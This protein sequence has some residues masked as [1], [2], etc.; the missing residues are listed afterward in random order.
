MILV[1][2]GLLARH[3]Q[4]VKPGDEYP[5]MAPNG[6][7]TWYG[8]PK[9][10]YHDG[11]HE[12]TYVGWITSGGGDVMVG[13]YNHADGTIES[14][15]LHEKLENDDHDHPSIVIR[16]DGHVLAFYSRHNGDTLFYRIS[17]RPE[18]ITE[19]REEMTIPL[20]TNC[21]YPNVLQL[22]GEGNRMYV[23]YRGKPMFNTSDDGGETWT[24]PNRWASGVAAGYIKY[25]T[26]GNDEIHFASEK[27][28]RRKGGNIFYACYKGGSFYRVDGTKIKDLADGELNSSQ[29]EVI[30]DQGIQQDH[31]SVWDIALDNLGRPVIVYA[32]G[33]Q[34][35]EGHSYW[36]LRWDG[37][38]WV[39]H[40]I[41]DAGSGLVT[42]NE[43]G[44]SGGLTLDHANPGVV[45]LARN[46]KVGEEYTPHEIERWE[47]K[48]GGQTWSSVAIT[49][50]SSKKNQRPCVPRGNT[51]GEVGLVWL[52]GPYKGLANYETTVRYTNT[53][54]YTT[55]LRDSRERK[56]CVLST[57]TRGGSHTGSVFDLRGRTIGSEI[58]FQRPEKKDAASIRVRR[59]SRG[60]EIETDCSL[61]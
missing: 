45:Y 1:S 61:K 7:W 3:A 30:Y 51:N 12:K 42:G 16:P 52:Y 29:M 10:F 50:N 39:R 54:D 4:G 19:W 23:F 38:A 27:S 13:S 6:V 43:C 59:W 21:T 58:G 60:R 2:I 14:S 20:T 17:R 25:C 15:V 47:T 46:E 35:Y 34:N 36:Y 18:D 40:K 49:R 28:H 24:Q 5:E 33:L 9:A 22:P 41:V 44:F 37:S 56:P 57:E 48:D 11:E 55:F 31:A 26:N 32:R 8:E 53:I